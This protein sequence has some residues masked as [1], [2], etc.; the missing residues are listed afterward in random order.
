MRK[1]RAFRL[2]DASI[3]HTKDQKR[4]FLIELH[5]TP[6]TL[7]QTLNLRLPF[8]N[9]TSSNSSPTTFN[10]TSS[11]SF[12]TIEP[13]HIPKQLCHPS[14]S[15]SWPAAASASH[16]TCSCDR[17]GS[18]THTRREAYRTSRIGTH[19]AG[20]QL[21]TRLA[22]RQSLVHISRLI[23]SWRREVLT[24]CVNRLHRRHIT[25]RGRTQGSRLGALQTEL[26]KP[27]DRRRNV[28][29]QVL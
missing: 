13:P 17:T 6:V 10:S 21:H 26:R 7:S 1:D 20:Q 19:L 14:Q 18:R 25:S 29:R 9:F 28:P 11:T 16:T 23:P 8:F 27:E 22:W 2:H 5:R 3:I 24:P 12:R 4:P 15:S